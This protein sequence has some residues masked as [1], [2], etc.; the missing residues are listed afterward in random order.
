MTTAQLTYPLI[1]LAEVAILCRTRMSRSAAAPALRLWLQIQI[2]IFCILEPASFLSVPIWSR[3]YF[4]VSVVS[5]AADL[6]VLYSVFYC[7]EDGFPAF[8]S[9]RAWISTALLTGM[10]FCFAAELPLPAKARGLQIA[11]LTADQAFTYIRALS[12][13]AL[14]LYGWLRASSW[15][16]DLAWTW[17][18]MAVYAITD[19]LVTRIQILESNYQLLELATTVAAMLQLAGWWLAL[20]Y[21]PK[22]LSRLDMESVSNTASVPNL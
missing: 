14:S 19:A 12:L 6:M 15:P 3:Y 4:G 11:W 18:G 8:G 13:M 22:P 2:G 17:I 20:S 10:L 21:V 7:L 9:A 5:Y 16:R 1:A